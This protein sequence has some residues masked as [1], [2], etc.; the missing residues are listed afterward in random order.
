[1]NFWKRRKGRIEAVPFLERIGVCEHD[2]ECVK[3]A[4]RNFF[5]D[6]FGRR[7]SAIADMRDSDIA[8]EWIAGRDPQ[9]NSVNYLSGHH[10]CVD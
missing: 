8:A 4:R 6:T 1:M 9:Q 5:K 3:R 10:R 2:M 7:E